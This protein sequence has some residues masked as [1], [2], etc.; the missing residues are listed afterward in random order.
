MPHVPQQLDAPS[1]A[2]EEDPRGITENGSRL[3]D[4]LLESFGNTGILR[5]SGAW[6]VATAARARGQLQHLAIPAECGDLTF[7]LTGVLRLDTA[8]ALVI[9]TFRTALEK[10]GIA[11]LLHC[12]PAH[13]ALIDRVAAIDM[14]EAPTVRHA[15]A[16]ART[17]NAIGASIVEETEQAAGILAFMGMFVISLVGLVLRPWRF[18]WVSLCSHMEQT[19]VQ[20]VPI[21]ALLSF[22]IGLVTAYMGA[23]QFARFGAQVFVINLLEISTLREMGVL[24][25]ALVVAGRS[26]SS[27][28]AQIGAMVANEEVSAMRALGLDPIEVLVVP[29]VLALVVM[30]PIL[31]FIA[32]IMGILGGGVA[33]WGTLGIDPAN[34]TARFHEIVQLRNFLVGMIKAPFFALVIALVGCFQGFRVTGSAESVGRLTTQAVVEAIFM[35]IVLNALFA[36]LFTSLGV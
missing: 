4:V 27:F 18:R 29:R 9:T 21:V 2:R 12:A 33:A 8:G 7:D 16:L 10:Q 26:G 6:D 3:P 25:T 24:L 35:V 5:F 31:A 22:L 28:T 11:P 13:N 15:S 20:A 34:F 1:L 17:L 36:I 19:G 14:S 32:D 23:E 30:L